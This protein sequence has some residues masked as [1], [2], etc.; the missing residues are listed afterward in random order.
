MTDRT[1]GPKI[2]PSRKPL[3]LGRKLEIWTMPVRRYHPGSRACQVSNP[4]DTWSQ[5]YRHLYFGP[6]NGAMP[7]IHYATPISR[8][9]LGTF[10]AVGDPTVSWKFGPNSPSQSLVRA[11]VKI[12]SPKFQRDQKRE[13]GPKKNI[14]WVEG[15]IVRLKFTQKNYQH[16]WF[17]TIHLFSLILLV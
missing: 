5:S 3:F 14:Q 8:I 2:A 12:W 4:T 13:L 1:I 6:K 15:N 11:R 17:D 16:H 10:A 9:L 7:K